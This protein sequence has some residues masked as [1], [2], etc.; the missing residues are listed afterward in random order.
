MDAASASVAHAEIEGEGEGE[1]ACLYYKVSRQVA[2]A[3]VE[4]VRRSVLSWSCVSGCPLRLVLSG[5]DQ[6]GTSKYI[7]MRNAGSQLPS[8]HLHPTKRRERRA[9]EARVM[10]TG[11]IPWG[12]RIGVPRVVASDEGRGNGEVVAS[13]IRGPIAVRGEMPRGVEGWRGSFQFVGW[14]WGRGGGRGAIRGV[15]WWGGGGGSCCVL[16]PSLQWF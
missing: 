13:R 9:A 8:L 12:R 7:H 6:R 2:L 5:G 1:G 10:G 3:P 16:A 15:G 14:G 4:S 11:G